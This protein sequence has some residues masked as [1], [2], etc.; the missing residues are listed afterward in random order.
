M[1]VS[2]YSDEFI[3]VYFKQKPLTTLGQVKRLYSCLSSP[4]LE[5]SEK[6]VRKLLLHA[7][8]HGEI[9]VYEYRL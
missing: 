1:E 7:I 3:D 8:E 4:D 6:R 9:P 2:T 5:Q